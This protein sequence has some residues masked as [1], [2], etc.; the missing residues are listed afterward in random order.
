[1]VLA[2]LCMGLASTKHEKRQQLNF[3][4]FVVDHGA[5]AGSHEEARTVTSRLDKLGTL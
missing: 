5:R 3:H 2:K 1:M 4:A